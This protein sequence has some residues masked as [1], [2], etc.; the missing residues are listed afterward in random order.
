V[1][2]ATARA[3]RVTLSREFS[4]FLVELSIALH[5]H[6]MYPLEHPS[7]EPAA[8]S[9]TR[10]LERLFEDRD[11]VA[12]GVAR[13]QLIIEGVAT[14]PNQPVL[15]RL[16]EALHRQHLGAVSFVR[17]VDPS[18]IG[19]ALRELVRDVE[20]DGPIGLVKPEHLPEWRHLRLHPLT[21]DRLALV[22]T[23]PAPGSG[24][25]TGGGNAGWRGAELWIGLARAAMAGDASH[26]DAR[27]KDGD[28]GQVP[29]EPAAVA[30]AIDEHP[31][32]E[33][34][35][36]VIVGYL[37][38]IAHELKDASV[39]ETAALRRRTAR[40]IASLNPETLRR[41]LEMGGNVAQRRAFVLDAAH[42]MA[43][44]AVLEILRAAS[45]VSGRTISHGLVRMLSKL[46]AHAELGTERARPMA[47]AA[48][49]EQV[50]RL[51]SGWQLTDPN[52][53]VYGKLLQRL[54]TQAPDESQAQDGLDTSDHPH[55]LRVAQMSLEISAAGPLVDR[56]IDR[57][58]DNGTL[59][60]LLEL[61]S[62]LPEH[63]GEARDAMFARLT[64]VR[65]ITKLV[66]RQP[67]D[68]DSLDRLLP[69]L[70]VESF[71][72]LLDTLATS[73]NRTIRRKLLDRLSVIKVDISSL[74]T[75]RLYDDRWF[76]QRNMLV[77]LE[78]SGQAP[79]GFSAATWAEHL[80]PRVRHQA[81]R[82]QLTL[83]HERTYALR[84]ALQDDDARLVHM[85]LVTIQQTCPTELSRFVV[86]IAEDPEVDEERRMLAVHA[87][88]RCRARDSLEALLK[89]VD[90]G[91]TMLGRPKLA[92]RTPVMLAAVGALAS[93]WT[94]DPRAGSML[95]LA[96]KSSDPDIRKAAG[97]TRP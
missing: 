82:F 42:G 70:P 66:A 33:A 26:L 88:G 60:A 51:L 50:G 22:V 19:G 45:D 40:L 41:L 54:T 55:P 56:A 10:R 89:M 71:N 27:S 20:R 12:L 25:G 87:L 32:A 38:Q 95:A 53:E 37:L 23:D 76:V 4:G 97:A 21:F 16:A 83:P 93:G 58:V 11:M 5:K 6:A 14:D 63:A 96:L 9:V 91:K 2:G 7:L 24:N 74:I 1:S 78:R 90:G 17:G 80:D 18:E 3:E 77:L 61:L 81:I 72:P 79:P 85:A 15:R 43:V 8:A 46:A 36:Q 73:E 39:A 31:R 34:Y 65:T 64:S 57:A 68:F 44:D 13:R 67:I 75:S 49:R 59:T 69:Q 92:P 48:L 47:D 28:P 30:Q 94:A 29:I 84:S 62:A 52:P 86:R 35:D